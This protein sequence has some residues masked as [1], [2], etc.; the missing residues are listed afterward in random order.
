MEKNNLSF[1]AKFDIGH[2]GKS[3]SLYLRSDFRK[4][5]ISLAG[6]RTHESISTPKCTFF[7]LKSQEQAE[8]RPCL[9]LTFD[10]KNQQVIYL[11]QALAQTD[12][13]QNLFT[14]VTKVLPT[15]ILGKWPTTP[16]QCICSNFISDGLGG[17]GG[18]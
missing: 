5:N 17:G 1:I 4:N 10:L 6:A 15:I 9:M 16:L 8:N 2:I 12:C 3:T 18:L 7:G 14:P 13:M 11:F